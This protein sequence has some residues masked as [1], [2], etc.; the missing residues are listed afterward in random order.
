MIVLTAKPAASSMVLAFTNL[1]ETKERD[2]KADS[3]KKLPRRKVCPT[4]LYAVQ[5]N[6]VLYNVGSNADR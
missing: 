4:S 6:S 2:T 5:N 3:A 1:S